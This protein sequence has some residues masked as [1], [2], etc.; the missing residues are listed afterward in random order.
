MIKKMIAVVLIALA[1]AMA[2]AQ[3]FGHINSADIIPLMPEYKAAQTEL[4]TLQKQYEEEFK[5][6]T[7]E[8]E[9]KVKEY[10]EQR[11]TLPE[12]I[13][14]RREQDIMNSR[15]NAEQYARDCQINLDEKSSS[16][17]MDINSKLSKAIQTVGEENAYV[18]IFDI[19]AGVVPYISS[20]LTTDVTEAVKAKLGIK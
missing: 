2:F 18:C 12:N 11:E 16:L 17:M 15:Q 5:Y 8:Y 10:E 3:K 20:T 13:R 1:P 6:M 4:E 7:D 9:K 14:T 19:A